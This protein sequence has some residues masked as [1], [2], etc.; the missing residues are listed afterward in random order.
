MQSFAT[1]FALSLVMCIA[2]ACGDST[3]EGTLSRF[4]VTGGSTTPVL[5][6]IAGNVHDTAS[7]PLAGAIV[8]IVGESQTVASTT[9]DAAGRFVLSGS[10]AVP[11]TCRA[12][13][14]GY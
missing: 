13:K 11:V 8:E 1:C 9:S 2:G 14:E 5:T 6:Q 12:S 10:F 7:K 4:L 3:G